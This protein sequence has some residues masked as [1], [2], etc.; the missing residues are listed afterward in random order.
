MSVMQKHE[1]KGLI[2]R[3]HLEEKLD[4]VIGTLRDAIEELE[5]K[6]SGIDSIQA[7]SEKLKN[8]M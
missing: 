8:S 2:K 1:S 6:D 5:T 7:L 4:R 3:G